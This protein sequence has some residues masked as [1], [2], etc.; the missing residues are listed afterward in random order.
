MSGKIA[1][2]IGFQVRIAHFYKMYQLI[3]YICGHYCVFI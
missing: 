2:K 3:C 1:I